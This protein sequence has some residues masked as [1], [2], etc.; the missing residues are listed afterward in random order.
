MKYT[1]NSVYICGTARINESSVINHVYKKYF[2]SM[3]IDKDTN[4]ILDAQ[5]NSILRITSDFVSDLLID[6][7]IVHDFDDILLNISKRYFGLSQKAIIVS[8]KDIHNQYCML[9]G[10][11]L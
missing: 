5:C 6:K 2:I 10:I 11:K 9:K 7:N 4:M 8:V 3:V 1:E